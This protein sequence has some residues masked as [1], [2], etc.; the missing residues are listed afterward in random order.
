MLSL[1]SLR[2][3]LSILLCTL[4]LFVGCANA[5]SDA[6][7]FSP[8]PPAPEGYATAYLYRLG[9]PPYTKEVRVLIDGKP[10]SAALENGYTWVH[11]RAGSR[12]VEGKWPKTWG[13]GGWPDAAVTAL[14]EPGKSYYFKITGKVGIRTPGPAA[15]V[16]GTMGVSSSSMILTPSAIDAEKELILCCRFTRAIMNQ[17]D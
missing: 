15:A 5:P 8:A 14:F 2:P 7:T 13:G 4:I 16:S 9:A 10:V 17:V 3:T 1:Q 12:V 6:P 11:V